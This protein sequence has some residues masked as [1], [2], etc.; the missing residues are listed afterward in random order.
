V[1]GGAPHSAAAVASDVASGG[2]S[3]SAT[4][5][6]C[7]RRLRLRGA[8]LDPRA[9]KKPSLRL[10][11][12]GHAPHCAAKEALELTGRRPVSSK[13]SQA[14]QRGERNRDA[15]RATHARG[16]GTTAID[17]QSYRLIRNSRSR[18]MYSHACSMCI[19]PCFTATVL[20]DGWALPTPRW[21]TCPFR[22]PS[23]QCVHGKG[24]AAW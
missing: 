18:Y 4:S 15:E 10:H 20:D 5:P 22:P 13:A 24:A 8:A 12:L 17:E 9:A 14:A 1:S 23:V 16:T 6:N 2:A 7:L 3:G 19:C 21:A 11:K